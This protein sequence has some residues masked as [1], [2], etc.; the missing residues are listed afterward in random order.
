MKN[1]KYKIL[2]LA[3][4]NNTASTILTSSVSLAKM[5][6]GEIDLLCVK[7]PIELIDHDN[8]FS[9]LRT[10]K[11]KYIKAESKIQK[12]IN[13]ISEK[14]DIP[15]TYSISHG[16]IKNEID[17]YLSRTNPD[18]IILGKKKRNS[19]KILK[20]NLTQFI[21]NRHQGPVLLAS[22]QN[23]LEPSSELTLGMYSEKNQNFD[24]DFAE[25]LLNQT[26][27]PIKSFK[28]LDPKGKSSTPS[29]ASQNK[30]IEYTFEKSPN[31]IDT[32]DSYLNRNNINLFY[33]ERGL[34]TGENAKMAGVLKDA[35]NKFNV[36]LLLP[37]VTKYA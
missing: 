14:Y 9:A 21:L 18:I 2:V 23:V 6:H 3:D 4:D 17:R 35:I 8:Q 25:A 12:I 15:I 24:I 20:D 36:S 10:V 30:V 26:N 37:G 31:T 5:I 11:E 34:D 32:L 19:F 22:T 33:I 1:K 16:N 28:V 7:R 29:Q 13:P 27:T